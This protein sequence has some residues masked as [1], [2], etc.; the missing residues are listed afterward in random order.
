MKWDEIVSFVRVH[1]IGHK[2][3]I[4]SGKNITWPVAEQF[5][6]CQVLDLFDYFD[7]KDN[8]PKQIF[9]V[10]NS[11]YSMKATLLLEERNK[12]VARSLAKSRSEIEMG[13]FR[14][15]TMKLTL[16][17]LASPVN[18]IVNCNYYEV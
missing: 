6:S 4:V 7:M 11:N 2:N 13:R 5:P 12:V 15:W 10:F 16:P 9:F 18:L 8:T 1:T 14:D 3:L 17:Y